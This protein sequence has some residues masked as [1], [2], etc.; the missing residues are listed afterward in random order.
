MIGSIFLG[1][2]FGKIKTAGIFN[3]DENNFGVA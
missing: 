2:I 3:V 1:L